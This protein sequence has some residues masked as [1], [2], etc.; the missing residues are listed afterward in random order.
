[1]KNMSVWKVYLIVFALLFIGGT[2]WSVVNGYRY[3][4][5]GLQA[6]DQ[7]GAIL[8]WDVFFERKRNV[9]LLNIF[10]SAFITFMLVKDRNK[11]EKG[12]E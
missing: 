1:M 11:D 6:C 5:E 10:G 8:T 4:C 12:S 7:T 9:F 3:F 2:L